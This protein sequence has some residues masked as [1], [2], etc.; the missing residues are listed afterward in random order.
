MLERALDLFWTKGYRDTKVR[1]LA[2]HVGVANAGLYSA[3][4]GK[5]GL[6]NKALDLYA[7]RQ[8]DALFGPME[9]D[10]AGKAELRRFFEAIAEGIEGGRFSRGCFVANT[11]VEIGSEESLLSA[12]I[13][14]IH[15]RELAA[16]RNAVRGAKRERDL[17]DDT[18]ERAFA[19]MLLTGFHG[20]STLTRAGVDRSLLIASC[21]QYA[22]LVS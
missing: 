11:A 18:D 15:D 12:R 6:F 13:A 3:F 19:A 4:K 7:R 21:R 9:A 1:D 20:L 14:R 2:Q 10:N 5:D 22:S 8:V 16:L 17:P